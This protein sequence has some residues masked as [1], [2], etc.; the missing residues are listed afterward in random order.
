[1]KTTAY[2]FR[3]S[4]AIAKAVEVFLSALSNLLAPIFLCF[5]AFMIMSLTGIEKYLDFE[6]YA[7]LFCLSLILGIILVIR[8]CFIY[9]GVTLYNNSLEITSHSLGNLKPKVVVNYSDISSVYN[10][11]TDIRYNRRKARKTFIAGD[12]KNYVELTLK[13]GKQFCFSVENQ[14]EFIDDLLYRINSISSENWLNEL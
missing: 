3:Y 2:D 1:M 11:R 10:N 6:V 14:E 13:N 8:Y 4:S 9:K 5:A 7:T 12:Y